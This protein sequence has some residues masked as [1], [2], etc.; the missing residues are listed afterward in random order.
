MHTHSVMDG[1]VSHQQQCC[2]PGEVRDFK[3]PR[4]C[5]LLDAKYSGI[6][7]FVE[8]SVAKDLNQRRVISDDDEIMAALCEVV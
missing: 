8:C 7:N 3:I 2:L 4:Q 6:V 5:S 1:D